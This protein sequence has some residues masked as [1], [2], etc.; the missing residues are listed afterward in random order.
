M[1][2]GRGIG[3]TDTELWELYYMLLLKDLGSSSNAARICELYLTD[4][5]SFK[6][7]FEIVG[8]RLPEVVQ[9]VLTRTGLQAPVRTCLEC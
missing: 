1:Y 4:D 3:L 5:L 7:D 2:V 9:F 6:R 8:T